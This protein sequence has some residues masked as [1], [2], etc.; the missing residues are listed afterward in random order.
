VC[1]LQRSCVLCFVN[2]R[3]YRALASSSWSI[4]ERVGAALVETGT[5]T[6]HA[7]RQVRGVM[8]ERAEFMPHGVL[9]SE[10]E[11]G[12]VCRRPGGRARWCLSAV[13]GV[14]TACARAPSP[15]TLTTYL[16]VK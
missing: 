11:R 1:P 10:G 9:V 14:A 13:E 15:P 8:E 4:R 7:R 3:R 2:V 6:P 12:G 16:P 5:P